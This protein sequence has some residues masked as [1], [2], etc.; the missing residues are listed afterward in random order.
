MA[1]R[2]RTIIGGLG[3]AVILTTTA[4]GA[5]LG[6]GPALAYDEVD[7]GANGGTVEVDFG[8]EWAGWT[9]V[10]GFQVPGSGGVVS[11][12]TDSLDAEGTGT[13]ETLAGPLSV[14]LSNPSDPTDD[15]PVDTFSLAAYRGETV[16]WVVDPDTDQATLVGEAPVPTA[17]SLD[18]LENGGLV[19]LTDYSIAPAEY[20]TGVAFDLT[21]SGL[22][23]G[24]T[25]NDLDGS[26]IT[27]YLY[28]EPTAIGT[29]TV[30]GGAYTQTIPAEFT[31]D[32]HTYASFDQ[33]G[34]LIA[35]ATLDGG[36]S[37][38]GAV[39]TPA[40]TATPTSTPT[41][42][43]VT[44][45]GGNGRGSLASTGADAAPFAIGGAALLLL[46]GAV[47]LVTRR[48]AARD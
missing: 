42:V 12:T 2:P 28:S 30:V 34:R 21:V 24:E 35:A 1:R 16:S 18:E 26:S 39:P 8:P 48:R 19:A 5:L 17:P 20:E 47:L 6:A 7:Q 46:G 3:A 10:A 43:P 25:P 11:W 29:T 13:L 4:A 40:T 44:A 31:T 23:Y 14:Y 41:T 36:A 22:Q 27:S 38:G 33:Y 15:P 32:P 45:T 37:S 9:A